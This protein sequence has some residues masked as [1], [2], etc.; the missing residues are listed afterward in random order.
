M[1]VRRRA[2]G[3]ASSRSRI[4]RRLLGVSPMTSKTRFARRE[5][6][7]LEPPHPTPGPFRMSRTPRGNVAGHC[8]SVDDEA[9]ALPVNGMMNGVSRPGSPLGRHNASGSPSPE[10]S[11]DSSPSASS[12]GDLERR[13]GGRASCASA[14]VRLRRR[15]RCSRHRAPDRLSAQTLPSDSDGQ[16]AWHRPPSER[17][18]SSERLVR[19]PRDCALLASSCQASKTCAVR[20]AAQGHHHP[21]RLCARLE[22][23]ERRLGEVTKSGR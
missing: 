12:G 21:R 4:A 22:H 10:N 3:E 11:T 23:P 16:V 9:D 18:S 20:G 5:W 15:R 8:R 7:G 17:P 1:R 13:P 2:A 19:Q 6:N 14:S